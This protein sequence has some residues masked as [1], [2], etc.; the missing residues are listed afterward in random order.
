MSPPGPQP[1][2]VPVPDTGAVQRSVSCSLTAEVLAPA[3]VELQ[4]AV[5]GDPP[6]GERLEVTLDG[7]P[8]ELRELRTACGG[9]LHLLHCE[10]GTLEVSYSAQPQERTS[11]VAPEPLDA[12]TYLRPSR[13]A[14]ADRLLAVARGEL[15][16]DAEPADLVRQVV[17]VV[18]RRLAYVPGSSSGTDG[19]VDTLLSGAGVCRDYAH[20]AIGLLRARDVPARLVSAYA[21]GL[22]PMDFHAVVE[23]LVDGSWSVVDA[24]LLAPRSSLVRIATG[25][26]A[27][28]TAFLS[29]YGG[30]VRLDAMQVSAVV[31][32]ELPRD[33]V[34]TQVQL[35]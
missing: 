20:L 11:P 26:D 12:T 35:G 1:A 27:A 17:D 4:V 30:A 13:Y 19:A 32:G 23:V 15:A 25:R 18:S 9:R 5:A 3:T 21:P 7:R 31:D 28:D 34:S 33:D 22:S 6:P 29:S 14:E 8:V 16:D 10:A 2:G 24:T